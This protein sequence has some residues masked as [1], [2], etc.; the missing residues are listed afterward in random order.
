MNGLEETLKTNYNPGNR[1]FL[2]VALWYSSL[3][4]NFKAFI[5]PEV[6]CHK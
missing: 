3:Y 6:L 2:S 5:M 4:F 1:L